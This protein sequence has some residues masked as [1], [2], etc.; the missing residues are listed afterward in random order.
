MTNDV[1]SLGESFELFSQYSP[2]GRNYGNPLINTLMH[3]AFGGNYMPKPQGGQ[4]IHDSFLLRERSKQFMQLQR[5]SFSNNMLFKKFGLSGN[6]F[7]Q[8][9]G[10]MA[11]SP[12]SAIG[13]G[14]GPFTWRQPH[15]GIYG[16]IF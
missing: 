6:P 1:D 2:M 14:Y 7:S 5:S 4:G 11:G 3:I 13:E 8:M 9:L 10:G 15:G 16:F 12:N